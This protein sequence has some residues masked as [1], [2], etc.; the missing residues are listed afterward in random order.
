MKSV[1]AMLLCLCALVLALPAAEPEAAQPGRG[2][3]EAIVTRYFH[4]DPVLAQEFPVIKDGLEDAHRLRTCEAQPFL[5]ACGIHFPAET[6]A[7]YYADAHLL[8]VTQTPRVLASIGDLLAPLEAF[9]LQRAL[10]VEMRLVEYPPEAEEQLEGEQTFAS[11]EK[12]VHLT[13]VASATL[14]TGADDMAVS[15]TA[16][17]KN[18]GEA[19]WPQV[20]VAERFRV[21]IGAFQTRDDRIDNLQLNARYTAPATETRPGLAERF[22]TTIATGEGRVEVLRT[23]TR[24]APDGTVHWYAFLARCAV[25]DAHGRS[26]AERL[27]ALRALVARKGERK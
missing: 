10:R 20:P 4:F 7:I 25:L 23:F 22:A 8:A 19:D 6:S 11:L 15:D 3:A 5:E 16:P 13:T 27:A 1:A 21:G 17:P 18:G 12:R 9:A 2:A 14:T 26:N 24:T